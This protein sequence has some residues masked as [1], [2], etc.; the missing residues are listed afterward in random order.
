MQGLLQKGFVPTTEEPCFEFCQCVRGM[1]RKTTP[2]HLSDMHRTENIAVGSVV[3]F[4]M[5]EVWHVGVVWPDKLH[6][7]HIQKNMNDSYQVKQE[8]LTMP[9]WKYALSGFYDV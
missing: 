8:S 7:T 3:L 1:L 6:F 4:S 9:P 2:D 5:G